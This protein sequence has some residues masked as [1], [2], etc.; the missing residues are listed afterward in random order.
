MT[1]LLYVRVHNF[2]LRHSYNNRIYTRCSVR[3]SVRIPSVT[4]GYW[5]ICDLNLQR[6]EF[7]PRAV[8]SNKWML[9]KIG[10][11]S[12]VCARAIMNSYYVSLWAWSKFNRQSL[13]NHMLLLCCAPSPK[14]S[15]TE[16]EERMKNERRDQ[17]RDIRDRPICEICTERQETGA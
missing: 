10:P 15:K 11:F 9:M 12:L 17:C 8:S 13:R 3:L 6:V 1:V 16:V 7:S 2:Y 4:P 5:L 14:K